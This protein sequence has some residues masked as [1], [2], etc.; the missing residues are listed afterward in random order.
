M[1]GAE[2]EAKE[3]A[4]ADGGGEHTTAMPVVGIG[5]CAASLGSLET[6]FASIDPAIGAAYLVAVR[7]QEGLD[8]GTVF[9]VLTGLASLPV[10]IGKDGERIEVNHIY[11]G[12]PDDLIAIDDGHLRIHSAAEPVGHRGTID[13]MLIS[14]AE[15]AHDRAVA[16]I[17][18]GLGSDGTAGVTATKRFGGLSI[19][20]ADT[21]GDA[22]GSQG[23]AGPFGAVDLHV[24][25]EQI[26]TQIALYLEN[27]TAVDPLERE[28]I[29]EQIESQVTQITTIL[30][31]VTSHDF[32]GYKRGTFLRR[33]HRRLQVLQIESI[34]TYIERLRG[35]HQEVQDLFQDLLIG[36]T[37]FFPRPSRIRHARARAASAVRRQGA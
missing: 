34:E 12:G 3:L 37:Q 13:T 9:D 31:N 27:L 33:V 22:A 25:A 26:A 19:A 28:G 10:S 20:E 35:D 21:P 24:P 18:G 7:Q 2:D 32:H 11:V 6:I 36:V 8:V 5:V 29:P 16:V 4:T 15:H 17:L 23:V 30:R 1:T 14:I